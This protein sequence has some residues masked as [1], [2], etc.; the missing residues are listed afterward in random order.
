MR[1]C[2][3]RLRCIVVG[4]V[5]R[6]VAAAG[7][8]QL[9][10]VYGCMVGGRGDVLFGTVDGVQ[11]CNLRVGYG[12]GGAKT[13]EGFIRVECGGA[14]GESPVEG[15]GAERGAAVGEGGALGGRRIG[16]RGTPGGSRVIQTTVADR[17]TQIQLQALTHPHNS[18]P[19]HAQLASNISGVHT[20]TALHPPRPHH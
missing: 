10:C 4:G 7:G 16:K 2:V 19:T 20:P 5:S 6:R 9:A 14:E 18:H 13:G 8:G 3:G 1:S 17:A 12:K 11:G 15:G